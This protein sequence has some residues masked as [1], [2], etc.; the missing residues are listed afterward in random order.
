MALGGLI[1]TG[2]IVVVIYEARQ[3]HT[4]EQKKNVTLM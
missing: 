4:P 2:I 1:N 3:N